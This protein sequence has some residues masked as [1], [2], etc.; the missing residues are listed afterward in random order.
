MCI[1]G[2]APPSESFHWRLDHTVFQKFHLF[3]G[4]EKK[5]FAF[6]ILS[7]M[8]AK[9]HGFQ[10]GFYVIFYNFRFVNI[11]DYWL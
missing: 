2:L 6:G 8:E 11:L 1:S 5:T 10:S 7:I 9:V 4:L 3:A